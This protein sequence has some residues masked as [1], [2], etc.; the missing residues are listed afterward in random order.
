MAVPLV[1]MDF[2][3]LTN[4]TGNGDSTVQ[5]W[6]TWK[7]TT[8]AITEAGNHTFQF[9]SHYYVWQ[10]S[11]QYWAE[12]NAQSTV[13]SFTIKGG[14]LSYNQHQTLFNTDNRNATITGNSRTAT[15]DNSNP[16]SQ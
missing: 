12:F 2:Q 1:P 13:Y 14:A 8:P 16:L 6:Y 15:M 7:A 3:G 5:D 11:D 4:E 10:D 9:F